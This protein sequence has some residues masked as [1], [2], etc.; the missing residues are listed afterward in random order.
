MV[1][2]GLG[3]E[4]RNY[5]QPYPQRS[6]IVGEGLVFAACRIAMYNPAAPYQGRITEILDGVER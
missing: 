1:Y 2:L 4:I 6:W 3:T 5:Q